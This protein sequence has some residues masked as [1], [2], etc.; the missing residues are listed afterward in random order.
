M[1]LSPISARARRCIAVLA[2]LAAVPL[3]AGCGGSSESSSTTAQQSGAAAS[4]GAKLIAPAEAAA[5]LKAPPAGLVVLD[6]RTPE[7]FASGHLAGA[8]MID[9]SAADFTAKVS[10]LD[11]A[12][13]YLVYCHSGNRSGQAVAAMTKLSLNQPHRPPRRRAGLDRCRAAAGPRGLMTFG[14]ALNRRSPVP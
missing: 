8:T 2:L 5:L 1:H 4:P 3:A 9:F 10:D 7:E 12:K 14:S 13:P 11:R 6:V